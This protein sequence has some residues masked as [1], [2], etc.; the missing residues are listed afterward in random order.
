VP[1]APDWPDLLIPGRAYQPGLRSPPNPGSARVRLPSTSFSVA[2][3]GPR[4][5]AIPDR[6][7]PR[8]AGI[9]EGRAEAQSASDPAMLLQRSPGLASARPG[10]E[11]E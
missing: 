9:R 6:A 8:V 3:Q 4:S 1:P 10:I 2:I 5:V 7:R 11:L